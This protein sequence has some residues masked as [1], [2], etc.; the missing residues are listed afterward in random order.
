MEILS[1]GEK[2]KRKRKELNMTLKDLA[3]DRITPGQ[4]SL[5]ESGRSNPSMDLL[6]Y[7]SENLNTTIEY[8]MESEETQAEKICMYYEQI[9]EAYIYSNNYVASE[10][11]IDDALIYADKYHLEYRKGR[12]LFPQ[13]E[14]NKLKNK[15]KDAQICYL[16]ANVIFTKKKKYTEVIKVFLNLGK[17]SIELKAYYSAISYLKQ[18]ESVYES[19]SIGDDYALGEIYYNLANVYYIIEKEYQSKKYAYLAKEK[20]EQINNKEAYAKSL[21]AS[22]EEFIKNGDISSAIKQ[23]SKALALLKEA[24][25]Q[26]DVSKIENSLGELFYNFDDLDES[27]KHLEYARRLRNDKKKDKLIDTLINICKNHIKLKNMSECSEILDYLYQLVD[28]RD[29]DRIIALNE[30]KYTI[31]MINDEQEVAER[32]LIKSYNIAKENDR[33][34]KAAELSVKISKFYMD[35]KEEDLS[36]K[37]LDESIKLFKT[38]GILE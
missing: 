24:N 25:K 28:D 19:N 9:A 10:K 33:L 1:L 3:K 35:N 12:I 8:L 14:L 32:I 5:I 36:K 22:S 31:S 34:K 29:I 23:S 30:L 15:L 7:L 38:I 16:S 4:I 2:I 17:V 11:Y 21:M 13:A 27:I 6:E 26:N 37:F 18:A 20:F